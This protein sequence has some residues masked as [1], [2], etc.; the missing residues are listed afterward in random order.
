M[1]KSNLLILIF[2][3]VLFAILYFTTN[4]N[5]ELF[6]VN[7]PITITDDTN[8]ELI[9]KNL[10]RVIDTIYEYIKYDIDV[11]E[12][13]S[14]LSEKIEENTNKNGNLVSL[15]K[16]H[17][18][19]ETEKTI[20]DPINSENLETIKDYNISIQELEFDIKTLESQIKSN[21]KLLIQKEQAKRELRRNPLLN[22]NYNSFNK[23]E[24]YVDSPEL[25]ELLQL[26]KDIRILETTI[27]SDEKDSKKKEK[28]DLE[29][30][31]SKL[32]H[33]NYILDLRLIVI[34]KELTRITS[35]IE[36]LKSEIE[37]IKTQILELNI[38]KET[39]EKE[40]KDKFDNLNDQLES[41]NIEKLVENVEV[42]KENKEYYQEKLDDFK[43][44]HEIYFDKLKVDE[45][46]YRS[47]YLINQYE[48]DNI[49]KN[50]YYKLTN[51]E[52][53]EKMD[54]L[55][56]NKN[57]YNERYNLSEY[58]KRKDYI[59]VCELN[60]FDNELTDK[61]NENI[62]YNEEC[63]KTIPFINKLPYTNK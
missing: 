43:K 38:K 31:L 49:Q 19:L 58:C 2:I 11:N 59:K 53:K 62:L 34:G 36:I 14:E 54:A 61:F 63:L 3:F 15:S 8:K 46:D 51:K 32:T 52:L 44:T 48:D 41:Y 24:E 47:H 57:N 56:V 26:D 45:N 39:K 23:K 33:D 22:N 9:I 20:K 60:V 13:I 5:I 4:N 40:R 12:L 35:E 37:V 10:Q 21:E 28:K 1:F 18:M 25:Q 6:T 55:C 16:E 27:L 30:E 17:E 29:L 7:N 50:M 42:L